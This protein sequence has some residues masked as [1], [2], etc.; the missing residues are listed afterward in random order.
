[1]RD[2]LK[3]SLR[4]FY[5]G[6]SHFYWPQLTWNSKSNHKQTLSSYF[7]MFLP[8]FMMDIGFIRLFPT[9]WLLPVNFVS[10]YFY[11]KWKQ[12]IAIHLSPRGGR[13]QRWFQISPR[14]TEWASASSWSRMLTL[15]SCLLQC[16][17][18][19]KHCAELSSYARRWVNS[20]FSRNL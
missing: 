20:M 2:S 13:T 1:M 5:K 8:T 17:A 7:H 4:E 10:T 14:E 9:C 16:L 19:A 11:S 12:R 6:K 15:P 3:K 18:V